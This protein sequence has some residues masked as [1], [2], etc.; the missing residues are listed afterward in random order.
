MMHSTNDNIFHP[1]L[2]HDTLSAKSCLAVLITATMLGPTL[3][4]DNV[5]CHGVLMAVLVPQVR[6]LELAPPGCQL[7]SRSITSFRGLAQP[8]YCYSCRLV[9]KCSMQ[10]PALACRV[11]P[12]PDFW[13]L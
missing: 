6:D 11:R 4:S 13:R 3:S 12:A 5:V 9:T 7:M 1:N 10:Q 8:R 2:M